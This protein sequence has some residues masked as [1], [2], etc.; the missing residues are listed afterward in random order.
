MIEKPVY[1][2][3]FDSA[4][5]SMYLYKLL[6]EQSIKIY[7]IQTPCCLSAGCARSIEVSEDKIDNVIEIIKD[8]NAPIR[9]I[10]KKYVNTKTKPYVYEKI[11]I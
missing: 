1:I 2:I 4:N 11:D 5:Y 6:K 9:A 7:M 3:T 8:K 10:H